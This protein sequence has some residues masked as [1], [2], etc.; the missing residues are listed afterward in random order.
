MS[1]QCLSI[2][3]PMYNE[4]EV[5]PVFFPTIEKVLAG[6]DVDWEIICVNDGSKDNTLELLTARAAQNPRIKVVSFSRNFG[7]EA[8]MT[9]AL[10]YAGGDAAIPIDADLQDPPELIHEM[11]KKWRE[12]YDVVYA[13]R[14]SR[15][16][17]S[18]VKRKTAHWFYNVFNRLSEVDIPENV[19]DYRLMSRRVIEAIKRLPEKERFM[20]GLFCW[21]G[22]KYTVIEFER[23]SRAMGSTK[24][25]YW[26]LWNFALSG[27]TSFSTMPIRMGMYLGLVIAAFAFLYGLYIIIK[28]LIL[29]VDEPGYAS[30]MVVVLFLGGVQLFCFGLMGEYIGRIYKE[31]KNRPLYVIEREIGFRRE[32]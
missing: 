11:L 6:I 8:A 5:I 4:S 25:N 9:A 2:L 7:K 10:D 17:D 19:G 15:A 18:L 26:K 16:S 24:F 13:R 32:Q 29:G 31:V 12:G 20:K 23:Q 14:A 21:P 27:I 30:L 3:V 28:T 22:F 1:R